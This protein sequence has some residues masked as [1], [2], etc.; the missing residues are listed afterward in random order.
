MKQVS[1]KKTERD[2][3]FVVRDNYNFIVIGFMLN[4]FQIKLPSTSTN[5]TRSCG[6]WPVSFIYADNVID[7]QRDL[8]F[9]R[10][11]ETKCI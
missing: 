3:W 7:F 9:G 6:L 8:R 4:L 1:E 11:F 10:T 2:C 5:H